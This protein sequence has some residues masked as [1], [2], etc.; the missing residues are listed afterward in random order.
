VASPGYVRTVGGV[1]EARR[2]EGIDDLQT[3]VAVGGQVEPLTD[4]SKRVGYVLA[5]GRTRDEATS[6]A[7]AALGRVQILTLDRLQSEASA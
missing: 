1:E 4:A 7:N 2:V 3:F 5:H 6:R